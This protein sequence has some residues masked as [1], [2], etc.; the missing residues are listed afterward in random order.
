MG[1]PK[2]LLI[3]KLGASNEGRETM[4][5]RSA[6]EHRVR[7]PGTAETLV[8]RKRLFAEILVPW[9]YMDPTAQTL[10]WSGPTWVYEE[11]GRQRK[12]SVPLTVQLRTGEGAYWDFV[13]DRR[14]L[15]QSVSVKQAHADLE[16][17]KYRALTS[18]FINS[19]VIEYRNR[20]TGFFLL[21]NARADELGE[22]EEDVLVALGVRGATLGELKNA[23]RHSSQA[24]GTAV[25]S[26][27]RKGRVDAPISQ[28][29]LGDEWSLH[30]RPHVGHH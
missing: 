9:S 5:T 11:K 12:A 29:L 18:S 19:N 21:V 23:L 1:R 14:G 13:D 8:F 22:V 17:R 4:A 26:L 3:N 6:M 28:S 15:P 2:P 24:I 25:L 16:G 20:R 7:I 10:T 30:R 27:W